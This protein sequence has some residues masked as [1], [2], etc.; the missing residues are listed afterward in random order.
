[1]I[2]RKR[3]GER[4]I[5]LR[6]IDNRTL[7]SAAM[8][9]GIHENTLASYEHGKRLPSPDRMVLIADYYDQPVE[10]LFFSYRKEHKA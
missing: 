7:E 9:I 5:E 6:D 1:M 3:V 4:L 2:D 8:M 10:E